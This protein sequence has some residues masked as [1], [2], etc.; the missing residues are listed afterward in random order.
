MTF[1]FLRFLGLQVLQMEVP[2]LGVKLE[3]QLPAYATATAMQDP[4]C[5]CDLHHSSQ[6]HQ[7]LSKA[8]GQNLMVPS[9]IGFLCAMMATPDIFFKIDIF[10]MIW[11]IKTLYFQLL[12]SLGVFWVCRIVL[13]FFISKR[14]PQI[15]LSFSRI[16]SGSLRNH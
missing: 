5:V 8:R 14:I 9:W 11:E 15:S 4:N 7:I 12:N 13:A 10:N 6:Q 16:G 3:L 1:F 2:R